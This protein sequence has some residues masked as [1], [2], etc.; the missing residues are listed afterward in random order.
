M[1]T[2]LD[3]VLSAIGVALAVALLI[4]GGLLTWASSFI[5]S[6]VHSQLTDQKITMPPVAAL[7]TPA[8]KDH[9]AQ[10]AGTPLDNGPKAKAYADYFIKVHMDEA[11]Q[12][13]SYSEVSGAYMAAVKANPQAAET[14]QL[15]QLRQTLFMGDT[16]RGLLLYGY[17]FATIGT[18]AGYAAWAAFA[19]AVVFL[20]LGLLGFRHAR[21]V[22]AAA[23][24]G[25]RVVS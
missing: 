7:T 12:G 10:Y 1:R 18:V 4:T 3:K 19:G 25:P 23:P 14:Q 6:E 16:L 8:Q 15:G 24:A 13:K 21:L 17:A 2:T 20:V 11:S 5:G 9:L 22:A